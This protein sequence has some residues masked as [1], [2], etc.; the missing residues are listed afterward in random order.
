[1]R[2]PCLR[3]SLSRCRRACLPVLFS[4]ITSIQIRGRALEPHNPELLLRTIQLYH[5]A[6]ATAQATPPSGPNGG[7]TTAAPADTSAG[8]PPPSPIVARVLAEEAEGLL[9]AGGLDGAVAGLV[10]LAQGASTGSLVAR[11]CAAKALA[12]AT[13]PPEEGKDKAVKIVREGLHGR[14]VTVAGCN[15]AVEAVRAIVGGGGGGGGVAVQELREACAKVFPV[16][17]AFGAS[18]AGEVA[19]A[20][21]G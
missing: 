19:A 11:V 9:G 6:A 10:E 13:T 17:E 18:S 21:S 7:A 16:A 1:M 3:C 2:L 15:A 20:P 8:P 4:A 12:L 14:G 5:T